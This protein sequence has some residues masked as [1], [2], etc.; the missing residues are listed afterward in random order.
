MTQLNNIFIGNKVVKQAFLNDALIY[1]SNGWESTENALQTAWV[2]SDITYVPSKISTDHENNILIIGSIAA[3]WY[4]IKLNSDGTM[5]WK[6]QTTSEST[7]LVVDKA[8]NIYVANEEY[9]YIYDKN[10][11]LKKTVNIAVFSKTSSK[12]ADLAVDDT[13]VYILG[14]GNSYVVTMDNN[15]NCL[16]C[17]D[18]PPYSDLGTASSIA[19]DKVKYVYVAFYQAVIRFP[20]NNF[21]NY[22]AISEESGAKTLQVDSINNLYVLVNYGVK[23][24]K[25]KFEEI[26]K[27]VW[28]VRVSP[29]GS[30]IDMILDTKDNVYVT[31]KGVYGVEEVKVYNSDGSVK[32]NGMVGSDA[33]DNL[34]IATDKLG[35]IYI[36]GIKYFDAAN[37]G[38]VRR[39]MITKYLQLVKK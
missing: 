21:G 37:G 26:N 12:I 17:Y 23:I 2:R 15:G 1:Q 19:V 30:G 7:K 39:N 27:P 20:K 3:N 9:I 14:R 29:S 25:Y 32:Y 11:I 5:L 38:R 10:G 16:A 13:K 22:S 36:S 31:W 4:V 24:T 18:I 6:A 8:N 35:N 34:R 28:E 33:I